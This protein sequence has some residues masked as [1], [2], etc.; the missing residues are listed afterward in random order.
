MQETYKQFIDNILSSRGRFA[1][2]DEYHERHHIVPKCLGGTNDEDNLIDLYA[3]EHFIA[4]KL[5]ALENPNND[6][7]TYAWSCMAFIKNSDQQR[8]ELTPDEYEEARK[9]LAVAMSSRV[10][11]EE[12]REKMRQAVSGERNPMYGRT[13]SQN[14]MYGVRFYGE[15]N[16][17]YGNHKIAGENNP[18]Y[19]KRHTGE[20]K[21]KMR[22]SHL[23]TKA[24]EETKQKQS[25]QRKGFL[26]AK[27]NA[28]YCIELDELFWGQQH[29]VEKYGF[30]RCGI[31][32][33]CRGKQKSAGKHPVTGEPLHW[34]Y[35]IDFIKKDNSV[36]SGAV[37]LGYIT[38]DRLN[39]Y[40]DNLKQKGND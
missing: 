26:N 39:N 21:E 17:N 5:L 3:K 34:L 32:D 4:H 2:G 14:P 27:A 12:T 6:K 9:A 40:L 15:D 38:E 25:E 22:Q 19:G 8:Y 29:A 13:G 37:T 36:L 28:V 35:A 20:S 16:P 11:S 23:G 31:G 7:L 30:N 18:F 24:S 1:C 33:C 10:V